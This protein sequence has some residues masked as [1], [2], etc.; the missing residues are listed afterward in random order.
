MPAFLHHCSDFLGTHLAIFTRKTS[1]HRYSTSSGFAQGESLGSPSPQEIAKHKKSPQ[2][3]SFSGKSD[4]LKSV[5]QLFWVSGL[6]KK[7]GLEKCVT[8]AVQMVLLNFQVF[9]AKNRLVNAHL[10]LS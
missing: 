5:K 4:L 1:I 9:D 10:Q 8:S 6:M 2:A 3:G 7:K